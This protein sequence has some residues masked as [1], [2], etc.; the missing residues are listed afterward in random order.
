MLASR[1]GSFLACTT[2]LL[3][4]HSRYYLQTVAG[5][6]TSSSVCDGDGVGPSI[7][8]VP[9]SKL[10]VSEPNPSWFGNGPNESG[11]PTWNT[12]SKNW[13]KSRFHFSFAE[14]RNGKN[15]NF[16][17]LRVMNDDLVQ[18]LRGF[19]AHP[20]AN[21]EIITYIVEGH[22]TH[23]D[24]LGTE[25]TIGRGSVQF[26]TAGRGIRHSEKNLE[27]KPLRF[28]QT[29]ITP[30]AYSLSPNYG[31]YCGKLSLEGRRNNFFH[32]VSSVGN[33]S[34]SAPVQVNQDIDGYVAEIELGKSASVAVGLGRQAYLLCIEGSV[35]VNGQNL[36]R[37]DACEIIGSDN[38]LVTVETIKVE[39]TETGEIAHVLI[40]I[41]EEDKDSSGRGDL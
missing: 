36:N 40:F 38:G 34:A 10:Y 17:V 6:S 23:K 28:I 27:E 14:Y 32:L 35:K 41:M 8:V 37:H 9:Q 7:T 13:L 18:P 12:E 19:G 26:M 16:G 30:A 25:E 15:T 20:H 31:S 29:W 1:R 5:M 24:S 2:I 33:S 3:S 39:A 22:L 11:N 21:M 4:C